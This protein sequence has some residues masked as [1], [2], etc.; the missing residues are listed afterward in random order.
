MYNKTCTHMSRV[1]IPA[2]E[3]E[4]HIHNIPFFLNGFEQVAIKIYQ[5]LYRYL[6]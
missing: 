3:E 6:Q 2:E 1:V 5:L 4:Q